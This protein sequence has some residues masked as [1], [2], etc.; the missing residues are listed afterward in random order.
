MIALLLQ[1]VPSGLLKNNSAEGSQLFTAGLAPEGSVESTQPIIKTDPSVKAEDGSSAVRSALSQD[2]S[3]AVK[4][5]ASTALPMEV[6][7]DAMFQKKRAKPTKPDPSEVRK[8]VQPTHHESLCHL[9]HSIFFSWLLL[10]HACLLVC[11]RSCIE[12]MPMLT[13]ANTCCWNAFWKML[14]TCCIYASCVP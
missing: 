3:G 12:V 4:E 1:T 14:V 8:A 6:D 7:D 9:C 10:H 11:C 2:K 13:H 5:E